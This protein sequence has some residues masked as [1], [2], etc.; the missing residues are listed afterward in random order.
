MIWTIPPDSR[1]FRG[2]L[3]PASQTAITPTVVVIEVDGE[4]RF[5]AELG[6]PEE[7]AAAQPI[8]I[9]LTGGRQLRLLVDF[10]RRPLDTTP[11]A[12]SAPLLGGPI[13]LTEP[14]IER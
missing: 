7:A 9:D 14:L 10:V 2:I 8:D 5:R 1:R 4:G 6:G 3:Q 13:L 11:E 12:A